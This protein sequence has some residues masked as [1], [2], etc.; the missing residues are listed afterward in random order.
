MEFSENNFDIKTI[1]SFGK[2]WTKFNQTKMSLLESQ[3]AFDE[4]FSI[5]PWHILPNESVGFDMGCGSGRWA[6]FVAPKVHQLHCIDPSIAIDIAKEN[7][8]NFNNIIFHQSTLEN[9][10]IPQDS[11]DFGYSLGVLHHIPNTLSGIQSCSKL[12]KKGAPL[13]LYLYYAFENRPIWFR[14]LWKLS[15]FARRVIHHLPFRLK[16]VVTDIIAI[17]IYFPFA[18]ISK[19]LEKLGFD[20]SK[21]PLSYYRNHTFYTLRTDSLD[22]FGTPL[23]NRFTR[24]QIKDM[25]EKSGLTNIRFFD[26]QP[27]WCALGI[28]S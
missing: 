26:Y 9:S 14:T 13:L 19:F 10:G 17:F 22:R 25:M 12:L 21:I 18:R 7:L 2:E 8:I 11:M 16:Q 23:E 1:K 4:Y 20:V 6:K 3:K 5:F 28:K 15:D 24:V 27:Y